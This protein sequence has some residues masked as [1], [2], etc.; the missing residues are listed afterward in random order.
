MPSGVIGA[1][2]KQKQNSQQPQGTEKTIYIGVF[3]DGTGNNKFQV[4]LGK[5]YRGKKALSNIKDNNGKALTIG[6]ARRLGRDTL[7]SKGL[8]ESQLD[9]IFFGYEHF[10]SGENTYFVEDSVH[11]VDLVGQPNGL[12]YG[13][14]LTVENN[15]NMYNQAQK[16]YESDAN[17]AGLAEKEWKDLKRNLGEGGDIQG[18]TYTNVAILESIYKS[19]NKEFYPIY[20]E[21]AGTNLSM[22]LLSGV[23]E[24][25]GAGTGTGPTGV[26]E[27][28]KKATLAVTRVCQKYIY[29]GSVSKLTIHMSIFG[30]SR[31]A[32]EARMFANIFDPQ[33]TKSKSVKNGLDKID[34]IEFLNESKVEKHLDFVGL[35][36]TV[37]SEG[38]DFTNDVDDLYLYGVSHSDY[39]LH[40][41]AM[42]EFRD[43]FAL[44]D[45]Q[46][47]GNRGLEL[48]IPGC[49]TDVGGGMSIGV[50]DWRA[51][52]QQQLAYDNTNSY[53]RG[54][55]QTLTKRYLINK[56]NRNIGWEC[57]D[58]S[59]DVLKDMGWLS[60]DSI[61]ATN[62]KN[63]IDK[64][65]ESRGSAYAIE[66]DRI[67]LK[68]YVKPGY[69]NIPLHLM[70][71]KAKEKSIPFSAIPTSY[72]VKDQ[73]LSELLR[74][75]KSCMSSTGQKFV[76]ISSSFY[77]SLRRQ[78]LQFSSKDYD[79]VNSATYAYVGVDMSAEKNLITR[80][81]YVGLKDSKKSY[82]LY[83]LSGN[84][85]SE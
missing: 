4:M 76:G 14:V 48:F 17:H 69:S 83:T 36:D 1:S 33:K 40:L 64:D 84:Q 26:W 18:S 74:T 3:F 7:K 31:G 27:K 12:K 52:K 22:G 72:C 43:N 37:S 24:P 13:D 16:E 55:V 82:Y 23:L 75:W 85:S 9:E 19:D 80:T 71:Q 59:V 53:G 78:Y 11:P 41:C 30:F 81:I 35:F 56:W 79:L 2:G 67:S 66:K 68:R 5:M 61:N 58:V 73:L 6:E 60:P 28:V 63:V 62:A 21:G 25:I 77:R 8:S 44:T 38:A 42:D 50:G 46:S 57:T 34:R 20:V 70:H 54:N 65:I 39:T 32:T 49:H 15:M 51:I 29:G 10:Q 47:V 45:I